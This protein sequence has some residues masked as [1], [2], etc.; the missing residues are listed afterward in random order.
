MGEAAV[1]THYRMA[2]S[3]AIDD[4]ARLWIAAATLAMAFP[5]MTMDDV[6]DTIGSREMP[7]I[8]DC[9]TML[10]QPERFAG[11]TIHTL[12]IEH[13]V[14][15]LT[16]TPSRLPPLAALAPAAPLRSMVQDG[17]HPRRAGTVAMLG[18]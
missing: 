18:R 13:C 8:D 16:G 11:C 9:L 5:G 12:D 4:P 14:D 1:A 17:P 7:Q 15:Q 10:L 6:V 3:L 2:L